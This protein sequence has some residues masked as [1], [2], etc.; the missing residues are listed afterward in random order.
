MKST[1]AEGKTKSVTFH[2]KPTKPSTWKCKKP[3][4]K[5]PWIKQGVIVSIL[6]AFG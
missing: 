4:D 1:C 2:L 6:C 3:C 5:G